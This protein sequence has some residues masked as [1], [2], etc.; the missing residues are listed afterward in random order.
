[1]YCVLRRYTFMP[2]SRE[3]ILRKLSEGF[4]PLLRNL[5]GFVAYYDFVAP[6]S[7]GVSLSIFAD[8]PSAEAA[9]PIS[10]QYLNRHVTPLVGGF[11]LTQG[12]L[13]AIAHAGL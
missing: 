3:E 8:Q 6:E 13:T 11:E 1:M 4:V 10:A 2:E 5:P 9:L 12:E 7:V